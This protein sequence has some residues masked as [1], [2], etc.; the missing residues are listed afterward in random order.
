MLQVRMWTVAFIP[1]PQVQRHHTSIHL[2]DIV[3]AN[4]KRARH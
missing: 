4:A 1:A 3:C 2:T